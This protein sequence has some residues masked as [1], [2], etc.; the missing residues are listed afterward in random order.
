MSKDTNNIPSH[1]IQEKN[2]KNGTHLQKKFLVFE[3]L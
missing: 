3:S 2:Y 1:Y